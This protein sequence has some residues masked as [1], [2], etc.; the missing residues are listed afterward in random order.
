MPGVLVI[1]KFFIIKDKEAMPN[2]MSDMG[3]ISDQAQIIQRR[4]VLYFRPIYR[5]M[6]AC[7]NR[8]QCFGN[9][10]Q[11]TPKRII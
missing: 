10:M 11:V 4:I 1:C 2:T 3:F 8:S 5:I 9:Q 7:I 6:I